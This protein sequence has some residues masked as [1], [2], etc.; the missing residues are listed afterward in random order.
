MCQELSPLTSRKIVQLQVGKR[1][2]ADGSAR[3][4]RGSPAKGGLVGFLLPAQ[5]GSFV[6]SRGFCHERLRAHSRGWALCG[7]AVP[8]GAARGHLP[9]APRLTSAF[10]FRTNWLGGETAC[11]P[12]LASLLGACL[13]LGGLCSLAALPRHRYWAQEYLL[14]TGCS[15]DVGQRPQGVVLVTGWAGVWAPCAFTEVAPVPPHWLLPPS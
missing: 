10:I 13:F 11:P 14:P 6:T 4:T 3:M 1:T 8:R 7:L 9:S 5:T 12:R 15:R 2:Q